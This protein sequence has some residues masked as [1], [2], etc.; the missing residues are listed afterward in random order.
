M[1]Y[2]VAIIGGGIIGLST[3]M[4]ILKRYPRARCIVI[5][6]E[7]D[8]AQHQTGRNSGVIHSGIYYKPESLKARF[9]RE[10]NKALVTFCDQHAIP[11][12]VCGKV[13]VATN[14]EELP[15]LENLYEQGLRNRL[16]VEKM[17]QE[18]LLE[19]EPHV[20]GL[21][22]IYVKDCGIV[23]YGDVAKAFIHMIAK[24]G[25]EYRLATKVEAIDERRDDVLIETNRGTIRTRFFINCA[26]LHSDRIVKM[27][28]LQTDMQIVP[29]RGE[30]YELIPEKRSLV[31]NLIYPVPN[32]NFPFLGVHLTRMIDGTVHAGPN[33]VLAFKREGYTKKDIHIKDLWEALTYSGFW[34]MAIPNIKEG[35]SEIVRSFS[36][37]AFLNSLKRLVPELQADD[38]IKAD[39]GVRAQALTKEGHLVEDFAIFSSVSSLHVCNAPSPAATASILI[40]EE[41]TNRLPESFTANL[42]E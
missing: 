17:N 34:K 7:A 27:V 32:P 21:A 4:A 16:R 23:N 9:A 36:K 12:E 20:N 19:I 15:L 29:F 38:L 22:A 37:K 2:D 3:C 26:G 5:E 31:N 40:G 33:A 6:K 8:W 24:N 25:G 30:Y 35:M 13:I 39:A 42:S 28:G 41:V 14:S 10:G 1:L 11:Y 18:Q